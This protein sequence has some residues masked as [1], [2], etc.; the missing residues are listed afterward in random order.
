MVVSC[1]F[2]WTIYHEFFHIFD[3]EVKDKKWKR[4]NR[5]NF[6]YTGNVF[7]EARRSGKKR[8]SSKLEFTEVDYKSDFVSS[9]AMSEE[10]EDRAE[11]FADMMTEGKNFLRRIEKNSVIKKKMEYIIE[12]TD[13]RKLMGREFWQKHLGLPEEK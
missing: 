5:R 9:Y 2:W 6:V 11:T 1:D 7:H 3:P 4:I 8:K 12:L 10:R 13:K